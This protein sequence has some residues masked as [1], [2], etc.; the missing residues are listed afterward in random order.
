MARLQHLPLL[1]WSVL[2][3]L[4]LSQISTA[5]QNP[6]VIEWQKSFGG[7]GLDAANSIQQTSDGG[8]IVA[9]A[10]FSSNGDVTENHGSSD[11]ADFW[12]VKLTNAGELEWQRPLGGSDYDGANSIQQTSDGG[13]IVAGGSGSE[14]GDVTGLHGR[15]DFWIVKLTST[16]VIQWQRAL[17]GRDDDEA[18]SIQQTRDGGYIVAGESNSRDGDVRGNHGG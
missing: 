3:V 1:A 11:S 13:Y 6:P 15:Y 5:Q 17:G 7:S 8:Y 10:S 2:A 4:L 18:N 9:G 14:D 12:I 16:G